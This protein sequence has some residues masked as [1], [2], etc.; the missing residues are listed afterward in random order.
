MHTPGHSRGSIV[1]IDERD[2]VIFTG[3]TLFHAGVGRTDFYGSDATEMRKSVLKILKLEGD[4]HVLP[5][6]DGDCFL[7]DE[8]KYYI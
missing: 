1:L 5:G 6:H 7:S 3:D 4:F 2:R 8:R